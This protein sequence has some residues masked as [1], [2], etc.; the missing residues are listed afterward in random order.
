MHVYNNYLY[1]LI[2]TK[3]VCYKLQEHLN[4]VINKE[5]KKIKMIKH[6]ARC[7]VRSKTC[8]RVGHND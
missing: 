3:I 5:I 1:A 4:K 8:K 6:I 2:G 7:Q